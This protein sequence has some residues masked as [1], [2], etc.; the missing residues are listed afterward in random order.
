MVIVLEVIDKDGD[1]WLINPKNVTH[2]W[3]F[4][5]PNPELAD[6]LQP[7]TVSLFLAGGQHDIRFAGDTALALWDYFSSQALPLPQPRT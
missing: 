3:R 7:D 6:P 1:R 2:I 5:E 4:K